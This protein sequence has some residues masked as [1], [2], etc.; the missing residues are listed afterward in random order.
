MIFV[1]LSI[2]EIIKEPNGKIGNIHKL[3]KMAD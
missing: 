1:I 3:Y 2:E